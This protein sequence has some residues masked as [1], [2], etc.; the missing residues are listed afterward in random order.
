MKCLFHGFFRYLGLEPYAYFWIKLSFGLIQSPLYIQ[1]DVI[2]MFQ[3][4]G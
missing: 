4:Y 2:H 1:D 3:T